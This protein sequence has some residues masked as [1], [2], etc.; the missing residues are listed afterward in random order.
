MKPAVTNRG[1]EIAGDPFI[2]EPASDESGGSQHCGPDEDEDEKSTESETE[3][4]NE[5]SGPERNRSRA[6]NAL[7]REVCV[8]IA[9]LFIVT[10]ITDILQCIMWSD[11]NEGQEEPPMV[12]RGQ[13]PYFDDVAD[14]SEMMEDS[15]TPH[16]GRVA[17]RQVINTGKAFV[18]QF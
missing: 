2:S 16:Q 7:L 13:I 5:G 14:D 18:S 6:R 8:I 9:H 15:P 11:V 17:F 4:D 12:I 3:S 10:T 1:K